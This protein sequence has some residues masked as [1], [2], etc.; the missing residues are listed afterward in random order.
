MEKRLLDTLQSG[1]ILLDV[2]CGDG[3]ALELLSDRFEMLIGLDITNLRLKLRRQ[4]SRDWAFIQA[5]GN[6]SIPLSSGS[7]DAVLAN[8]VIEHILN[9]I[10]FLKELHR[11]LKIGGRAVLTTPNCRYVQHLWRLIVAGRGPATSN[12]N[13]LDGDW[14]DGHVHYFTHRDLRIALSQCGFSNVHSRGLVNVERGGSIRQL[15]D[16]GSAFTP[17][18]E[19]G[20]GN[21]LITA[22]KS[23]V[24]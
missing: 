15:F 3:R 7:V 19:F 13:T 17:V 9:P 11:V 21:I 10:R 23:Y 20:T 8:Q 4:K 1:G 6:G 24:E 2:G 12:G 5:D 18:R 22:H 16:L 14:D